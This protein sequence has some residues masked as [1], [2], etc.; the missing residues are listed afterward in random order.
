MSASPT[1]GHASALAAR[2]DELARLTPDAVAVVTED[3]ETWT[4]A[5]LARAVDAA[6][7]RLAGATGPRSVLGI[8]VAHP[9]TFVSLYL[10]AARLDRVAVLLDSRLPAA[11]LAAEVAKL[12]VGHLAVDAVGAPGS[13]TLRDARAGGLPSHQ[14]LPG[15]F[16]VHCTSGSTG[17]SKGIVMSQAAIEARVRL[18]STTLA[19][20]AEDVVLCALPLAHCHGIDVLTLPALMSGGTVVFASAGRLT[21]RALERRI[22][23]HAVTVVSGLPLMYQMLTGR[24]AGRA[25]ALR[26]LR[27]AI[28]GSAPLSV[29]T[30]LAFLERYSV[31]LQQV[32][33]LSEIGVICFDG[34]SAG[35]GSVGL[36]IEGV[37]WRLEP[38]TTE[39]A[40]A[41]DLLELY[42]RGPAL[43]RGY[44]RDAEAT[45]Q[46]FVDG[47]LR[48]HDLVETGTEGWFVRGRRST[49]INVAG[50]KVGPLEV[51]AAL[52]AC[53]G[54]VEG[55]VVGLPDAVCTEVVAALVAV[56]ST[57]TLDVLRH[58]LGERLLPHQLPRTVGVTAAVPRTPLGKTDYAAVRRHLEAVVAS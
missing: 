11:D 33:G 8:A 4:Y 34:V 29:E 54:V 23:R 30:Q 19:L 46:M 12:D 50:S 20:S 53:T 25:D 28:S 31:P 48:T 44:Y 7:G 27:L 43:A 55:A 13:F 14:Y 58:E 42:V 17:D 52:S 5:R 45:E 1:S 51:E 39:G 2:V 49:F 36:P 18:W 15:D 6:T 47:W 38:A 56:D 10:A 41:R 3:D 21:G 35:N 40:G 32:Y 37:E 57:F 16:V 9:V 22:E 26:S 24:P